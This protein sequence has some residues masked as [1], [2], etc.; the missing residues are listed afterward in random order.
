M[1][2]R[3]TIL[4][5]LSL[6]AACSTT[7]APAPQTATPT[8]TATT[9]QREITPRSKLP[10]ALLPLLPKNGI[11]AS[12]G[13]LTSPPWRIVVDLDAKTIFVGQSTKPNAPSTGKLEKEQIKDLSARNGAYLMGFAQ[14][15]WTEVPPTTP[16][17]PIADYDEVLVVLQG[18][19]T[20]YLEGYGPIRRPEAAKTIVELRAAAGL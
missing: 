4:T 8:T 7:P 11:Y 2:R 18:E 14:T 12:G 15:A 19:D 13:G 3:W 17:E 6:V 1:N 10:P 16:P 9:G 20:F 5:T